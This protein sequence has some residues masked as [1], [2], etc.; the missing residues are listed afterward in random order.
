MISKLS[1]DQSDNSYQENINWIR[2]RLS[3]KRIQ[4]RVR[5]GKII[6]KVFLTPKGNRIS[7][8]KVN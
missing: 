6:Q 4:I 5:K 2:A 1:K 8:E 3:G 7:L